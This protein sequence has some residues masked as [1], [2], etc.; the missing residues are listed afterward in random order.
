MPTKREGI[1]YFRRAIPK[2][3]Q[4]KLNRQE[5]KFSLNTRDKLQALHLEWLC[6]IKVKEIMHRLNMDNTSVFFRQVTL[7]PI[8]AEEK[9][10]ALKGGTA[11]NHLSGLPYKNT[12][13]RYFLDKKQ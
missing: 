9:V 13:R 4:A 2:S 10:F 5:I 6:A 11:I 12:T 8:V 1:F 3:L 7:L